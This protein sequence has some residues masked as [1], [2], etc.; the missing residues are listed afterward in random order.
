MKSGEK[1]VWFAP[2]RKKEYIYRKRGGK[3][4]LDTYKLT[5][6]E[7]P[8]D[9]LLSQLMKEAF[10]DARKADAEATARYFAELKRAAARIR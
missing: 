1:D 3:M 10:D 4:T 9:E 7:E 8:S 2:F 5:S 6:T